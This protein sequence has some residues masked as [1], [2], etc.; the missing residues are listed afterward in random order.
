MLIW[1]LLNPNITETKWFG[2]KNSREY[3]LELDENL[4]CYAI[5]NIK[6]QTHM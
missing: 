4:T 6:I 1:L 2:Q 3:V 5:L